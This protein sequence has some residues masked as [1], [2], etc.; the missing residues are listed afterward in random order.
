VVREGTDG[1]RINYRARPRPRVPGGWCCRSTAPAASFSPPTLHFYQER[2]LLGRGA[3]RL[4]R[5]SSAISATSCS[6]AIR[7][8]PIRLAYVRDHPRPRLLVVPTVGDAISVRLAPVLTAC[9]SRHGDAP[10][11]LAGAGLPTFDTT[12]WLERPLRAERGGLRFGRSGTATSRAPQSSGCC[13]GMPQVLGGQAVG[14]RARQQ[15]NPRRHYL[16]RGPRRMASSPTRPDGA[17]ARIC[18]RAAARVTL[19]CGPRPRSPRSASFDRAIEGA[20]AFEETTATIGG[21]AATMAKS[22]RVSDKQLVDSG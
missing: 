2:N 4:H 9:L 14:R 22:L 15:R 10:E 6:A 19:R 12:A 16:G 20:V 1:V 7:R 13:G 3:R 8:R 21:E 18:S 5:W 17:A 11:A